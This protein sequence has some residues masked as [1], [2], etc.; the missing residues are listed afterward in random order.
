[1]FMAYNKEQLREKLHKEYSSLHNT[2]GTD[3]E[4]WKRWIY[5]IFYLF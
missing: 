4:L 2:G 5:S 3:S 1:M